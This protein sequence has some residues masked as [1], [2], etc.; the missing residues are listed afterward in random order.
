MKG[1][2]FLKSANDSEIISSLKPS[3]PDSSDESIISSVKSY[4]SIDAWCSNP[5]LTESSFENLLNMLE[6]AGELT[7][8]VNYNDAV[9]T[10]IAKGIK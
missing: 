10:T 7:S 6:N 5:L 1:Y 3:F 9:Y 4:I 2:K 8:R